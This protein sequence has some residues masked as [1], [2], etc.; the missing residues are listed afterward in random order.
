ME[1]QQAARG[2]GAAEWHP[3]VWARPSS[4]ARNSLKGRQAEP[5]SAQQR[6]EEQGLALRAEAQCSPIMV[7]DRDGGRAERSS[8]CVGRAANRC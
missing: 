7:G 6:A 2:L 8:P 4:P 5:L 3:L 1:R